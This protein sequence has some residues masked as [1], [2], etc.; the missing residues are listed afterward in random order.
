MLQHNKS[1]ILGLVGWNSLAPAQQTE[2]FMELIF[3]F[4]PTFKEYISNC[5]MT[6]S[7]L[8]KMFQEHPELSE[9]FQD[10]DYVVNMY[11]EEYYDS[12]E[13]S[14]PTAAAAASLTHMTPAEL[15]AAIEAE[16]AAADEGSSVLGAAS[17]ATVGAVGAVGE[18][19][20]Q[21]DEA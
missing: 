13:G 7:K 14:V 18:V 2:E 10:S 19:S 5:N 20:E 9:Y 17:A 12:L 11:Q 6:L 16:L 15:A 21:V 4:A 1:Q 3:K 8:Y